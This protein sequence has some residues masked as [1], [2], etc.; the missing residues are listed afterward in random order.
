MRQQWISMSVKTRER[1]ASW[2]AAVVTGQGFHVELCAL[3]ARYVGR[4]IPGGT[5]EELLRGIMLTHPDVARDERWL[6]RSLQH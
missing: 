4:G 2:Y 1:T 5:V 6:D 3:A